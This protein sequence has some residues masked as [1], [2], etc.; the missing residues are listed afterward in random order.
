MY[1]IKYQLYG[2]MV[3]ATPT[4]FNSE[5]EAKTYIDKSL[6]KGI[7]YYVIPE[8]NEESLFGFKEYW[9]NKLLQRGC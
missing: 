9:E 6:D 7:E 1:S 5:I 8:S 4:K 3:Y 2:H